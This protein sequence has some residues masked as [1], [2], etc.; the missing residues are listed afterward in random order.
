MRWFHERQE[1]QKEDSHEKKR[2]EGKAQLNLC[3]ENAR[4][5]I[6]AQS[7]TMGIKNLPS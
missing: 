7:I 5:F 1:V 4:I 3:Q 2:Q 6:A